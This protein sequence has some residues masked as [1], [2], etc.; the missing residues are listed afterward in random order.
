MNKTFRLILSG[1]SFVLS[2]NS[3]RLINQE[4]VL[5]HFFVQC[6]AIDVQHAGR[7]LTVPVEGLKGLDDD[8]F[9]G[10][11]EGFLQRP[12]AHFQV[13]SGRTC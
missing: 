11:L 9:L 5:L 8:A 10:F 4:V 13:R 7:F 3:H 6:R 2:V 12:D 1:S